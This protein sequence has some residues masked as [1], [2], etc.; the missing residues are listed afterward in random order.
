MNYTL[1]LKQLFS[2]LG[3]LML[4]NLISF[5]AFINNP[6]SF[7]FRPWEYFPE[8]AYR[9]DEYEPV[10]DRIETSDQTRDNFFYYQDPHRTFVSVDA[11]GYRS[12]RFQAD[13][14][15]I[16]VSGDS[17]VFGTG[18]SDNETL[19][20][21][22]SELM[23]LP[24][25]NGGRSSLFNTLK[26]SELIDVGLVIDMRSER[27]IKGEVFNFYG[28][29][30]DMP[31]T[32]QLKNDKQLYELPLTVSD[33]RFLFTSIASRSVLRIIND[34]RVLASGGERRYKFRRHTFSASDLDTAVESIVKR[35]REMHAH[36]KDYVFIGIPAKQT[37]YHSQVD[38]F[39]RNYLNQ[40]TERLQTAGVETINLM[41]AFS[42]NK[43]M[44]LFHKYDTHWNVRGTSI[45]ATVIADYLANRDAD[46]TEPRAN[47][48]DDS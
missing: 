6:E 13:H 12:T 19:P 48:S 9:F 35:Q 20:W 18:L 7:Y 21:R 23:D 26:R 42:A 31:Y 4:L 29:S 45:A 8:V 32:P 3:L 15:D 38:G 44:E 43:S 30:K 27:E 34:I 5:A 39:T 10:W 17:A 47:S 28:L 11:D 33:K 46:R 36:G 1:Y 40:L 41:D 16:V 24:V 25:F 37:L 2:I 22:L 14:Y